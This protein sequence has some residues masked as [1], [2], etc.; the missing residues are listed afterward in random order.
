MEVK[1]NILCKDPLVETYENIL[2]DEECEHFINISK[3]NLK[4]ALVSDNA[5]GTISNGRTGSNTWIKHDYDE[6]TERIGNKIAKIVNIPLENAEQYQIIYYGINE[7]YRKHYD[8]WEH[9]N[10]EKTLRCMKYGGA[11]MMTAL[12][13]LCD[14]EEGGGTQMTKLGIT[15]KPKKGKLLVFQNT[16]SRNSHKRHPLSE[17]AGLPVI[18]G[19]KYAFNLWFKE[20][21]SKLLYKEFNPEY[22]ILKSKSMNYSLNLH[23]KCEKINDSFDIYKNVNFIDKNECADI[24]RH[25]NFN[26]NKFRDAWVN[27]N[28]TKN[29]TTKLE[30]LLNIDKTYFENINVVEYEYDKKHNCHFTA[31]DMTTDLGK[32]YTNILGQ[33]LYTVTIALSDNVIIDF[34]NIYSTVTL[35]S[36]DILIYNNVLSNTNIRNPKLIRTIINKNNGRNNGY[37]ANIYIR[38]KNKDGSNISIINKCNIDMSIRE[39]ENYS[40]TLNVV[41]NKLKNEENYKNWNGF[42]S[43]T[44][45]FKGNQTTF[46]KYIN[47]YNK[48]RNI[49]P[50]LNIQNLDI[51]YNLDDELPIQ[52]VNNVFDDEVLQLLQNY[53]RE[54]ISNNV[55][56]LGDKQSNRFKAHN[57][58]LSRLLHYEIHPLIEK[59]VGKKIKPTYTYLSAYIKGSELPPHT[60]RKECEYTV[61]LIIDKPKNSNWNI[62]IHK[63]KQLEKNKGRYYVTVPHNECEAV[64]CDSGGLMLFQGTQNIHFRERL[65]HDY[66]NILLLHYCSI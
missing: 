20:C 30:N 35:N 42:K 22:Y 59:I 53:Y 13:Y 21:N 19:E 5:N 10:S 57:E 65:E 41:I 28:K 61:S 38:E 37:I 58:P 46:K 56:D 25:C 7:E 23:S 18:K 32:K 9:D 26:N 15:I 24:I 54:N 11:R 36:G 16:S 45:N 52:V 47:M 6:I 44:F 64:D 17:H 39:L 49:R 48:I 60:D 8:S 50:C 34:Q 43:F 62:Y 66:Y 29:T 55:W 1:H 12:V 31:Y 63:K 4:R 40:E 51:E 3:N 27:L 33:R 14:V 2:T